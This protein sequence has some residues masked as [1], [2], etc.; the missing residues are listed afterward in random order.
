[1]HSSPAQWCHP[2]LCLCPL[3]T[4]QPPSP[5]LAPRVRSGSPR[6]SASKHTSLCL[7]DPCFFFCGGTVSQS[8]HGVVWQ[9]WSHRWGQILGEETRVSSQIWSKAPVPRAQQAFESS[10]CDSVIA[11]HHPSP[12]G[13]QVMPQINCLYP[14]QFSFSF[15]SF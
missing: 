6:C 14:W 7:T 9:A 8:P 2:V 3:L 4:S 15:S 11:S 13:R 5:A 10:G 1:M 12:E